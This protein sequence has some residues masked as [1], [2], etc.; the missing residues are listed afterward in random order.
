MNEYDKNYGNYGTQENA[1]VVTM[2]KVYSW[3]TLA[4][5]ATAL[6]AL[7]VSQNQT[8][9]ELLFSNS[10]SFWV[11]FLGEVGLVMYISARIAR[12]NF[13]TAAALFG[14]YSILN[15]IM[16]S[17]VFIIYDIT[18][19]Y[20]AFFATAGTFAAMSF[21]GY[22]TKKDLTGIGGILTMGVIG[23]IVASLVN[24]FLHNDMLSS[25]ITYAGIFIFVGL[26]AYDTQK[27]KHMLAYNS[28]IDQRKIG[29]IGALS[30][31]LDFI[32]LFLYILRLFGRRN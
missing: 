3:M 6:T 18:T 23:L 31:Y 17:V 15:G 12:I 22:T 1:V 28:G 32:N 4:L 5:V 20:A 27:I 16:L 10:I 8:L 24:Y 29:I 2:N 19:I 13:A 7:Y 9:V 11:L 30:L 14:A 25:I 26:T 21:I